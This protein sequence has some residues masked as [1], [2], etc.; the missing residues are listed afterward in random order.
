MHPRPRLLAQLVAALAAVFGL[1]GAVE[2]Q[3]PGGATLVSLYNTAGNMGFATIRS[4]YSPPDQPVP[5]AAAEWLLVDFSNMRQWGGTIAPA[6]VAFDLSRFD[7]GAALVRSTRPP[8]SQLYQLI[9]QLHR[10]YRAAVQASTCSFGVGSKQQ[11]DA[12]YVAA[13]YMGFATGRASYFYYDTPTPREIAGQIAGDFTNVRAGLAAVDSCI[14]SSAT[15][16]AQMNAV[17]GRIGTIPGKQTYTEIAG[18]YQVVEGM[19]KNARCPATPTTGSDD[20]GQ[21]IGERPSCMQKACAQP[22]QG[23]QALLGVVSGPPECQACMAKNC[24]Q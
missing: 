20:F 14:G 23:A 7:T 10:D 5:Q 1:S 24:G 6:C 8:A 4:G 9:D 18:I 2:T 19:A 15:V 13:L 11:L 16:D 21:R 22:C 17:L 12:F 3:A